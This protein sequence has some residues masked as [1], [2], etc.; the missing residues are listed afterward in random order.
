MPFTIQP[1]TFGD[2]SALAS[3]MTSSRWVDPHWNA[4]F[5]PPTTEEQVTWELAQRL[6]WNLISGGELKRHQKAVDVETGKVVGYARWILPPTLEEEAWKEAQAPEANLD[7]RQLFE[8][9][10]ISV[11]D[12]GRVRHIR[13]D[14]S[15]Y[16]SGILQAVDDK[17]MA[18]GPFLSKHKTPEPDSKTLIEMSWKLW[19]ICLLRLRISEKASVR[20]F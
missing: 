15:T 3:V 14:L 11:T 1:V 10:Y 5:E 4:L 17:F 16:R 6:P 13:R 9:N 7:Q 18:D 2:V 19:I 8:K 20:S 12:S